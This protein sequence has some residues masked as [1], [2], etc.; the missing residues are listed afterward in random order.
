MAT[1]PN[2]HPNPAHWEFCGECGA[3]IEDFEQTS[4]H[5]PWYRSVRTPLAAAVFAVLVAVGTAAGLVI[6]K[7]GERTNSS[8][9]ASAGDEGIQEWWSGAHQDFTKLQTALD[10]SRRASKRLDEHA[11]E[12]ACQQMHDTAGVD[13]PAHL[14]TPDAELSSELKAATDDAH[15][16]AHMCL[17]AIAGSINSYGGEFVSDVD[18]AERHLTAAQEIINKA[19][20]DSRP[21]AP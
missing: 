4:I 15:A 1:C 17:S 13:L 7:G 18:Q 14:P 11:M 20:T 10:D 8:V 9:Q 3:P 16:A 21:A 5:Q 2:G 19:L 6:S 12:A